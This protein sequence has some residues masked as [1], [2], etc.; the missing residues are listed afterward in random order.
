MLARGPLAGNNA[1]TADLRIFGDKTVQELV[2][3][4]NKR[5]CR[6]ILRRGGRNNL[7]RMRKSSFSRG[8]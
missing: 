4:N 2:N 1:T 3:G 8:M 6:L 7:L 5:A